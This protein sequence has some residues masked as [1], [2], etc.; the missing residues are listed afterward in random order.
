M[1]FWST[2]GNY[3]FQ[4]NEP[5]PV[6]DISPENLKKYEDKYVEFVGLC[7]GEILWYVDGD[8]IE[9]ETSISILKCNES[10]YSDKVFVWAFF[11]DNVNTTE[12]KVTNFELNPFCGRLVKG[13]KLDY[14]IKQMI[15]EKGVAF[16]EDNVWTLKV[17]KSPEDVKMWAYVAFLA[18]PL[19]MIGIIMLMLRDD[20]KTIKKSTQNT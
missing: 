20:F 2:E 17:D 10:E 7:L 13:A 14:K 18:V 5:I 15:S 8:V 12:E 19:A 1:F 6:Y 9:E 11:D 3:I 16:D 4:S